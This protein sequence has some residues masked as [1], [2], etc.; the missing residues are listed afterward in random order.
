[1]GTVSGYDACPVNSGEVGLGVAYAALF[2]P[3][4]S[5]LGSSYRA[6]Y[7]APCEKHMHQQAAYGRPFP[8]KYKGC[9]GDRGEV[10]RKAPGRPGCALGAAG[11]GP[12]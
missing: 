8:P 1:M 9:L 11:R 4:F 6:R 7:L 12:L 5:G 10:L 3:A 2:A